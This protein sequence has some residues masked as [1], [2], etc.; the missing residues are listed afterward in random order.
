MKDWQTS[1]FRIYLL[2]SPRCLSSRLPRRIEL[3]Q[4]AF[5]RPTRSQIGSAFFCVLETPSNLSFLPKWNRIFL[6]INSKNKEKENKIKQFSEKNLNFSAQTWIR[7]RARLWKSPQGTHGGIAFHTFC[8]SSLCNLPRRD[9][10]I[11]IVTL[12]SSAVWAALPGQH[13][14]EK[15]DA[16]EPS[17]TE[18]LL[19]QPGL[20]GD[21]SLLN[22]GHS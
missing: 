18:S 6:T 15:L 3:R 19:V 4:H 21:K 22:R 14:K 11:W 12:P 20:S 5:F 13:N 17:P 8:R 16:W 9:P 2:L 1:L 7:W 10:F